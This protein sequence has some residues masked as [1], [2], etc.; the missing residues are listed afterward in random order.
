MECHVPRAQG[1][2]RC[3]KT[4]LPLGGR[5]WERVP[6]R[7]GRLP[8][9]A[10]R[11]RCRASGPPP[12]LPRERGRGIE[13]GR[14]SGRPFRHGAVLSGRGSGYSVR[15]RRRS[16]F[17]M[18]SSSR[19]DFRSAATLRRVPVSRVSPARAPAPVSAGAVRA[20]DCARDSGRTC[21]VC[22]RRGLFSRPQPLSAQKCERR[23]RK[24]PLSTLI[25]LHV[26]NMSTQDEDIFRNLCLNS[27][28]YYFP[29]PC[30]PGG[31]APISPRVPPGRPSPPHRGRGAARRPPGCGGRALRRLRASAGPRP[32]R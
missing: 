10:R 7:D 3:V 32:R 22:F 1:G 26:S 17:G 6:R 11:F 19:S 23:P 16:V 15:F 9:S 27:E 20:P 8:G 25:I 5:G 13:G 4:P 31:S 18:G 21:P 24:P 14:I 12:V 28:C 30:Q 29:C 2:G